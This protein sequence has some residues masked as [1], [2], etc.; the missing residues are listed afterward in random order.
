[1]KSVLQD[2]LSVLIILLVYRKFRR[3][4][5]LWYDSYTIL[6]F[7]ISWLLPLLSAQQ[8]YFIWLKEEELEQAH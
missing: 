3:V 2:D 4:A 7:S 8:I 1:M 6:S 5:S